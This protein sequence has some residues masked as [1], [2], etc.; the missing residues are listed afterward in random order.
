MLVQIIGGEQASYYGLVSSILPVFLLVTLYSNIA[1]A[2]KRLHDLGYAGFLALALLIPFVNL[3]FTI[4]VGILP[5]AAGPNRYGV[6][7][8]VPPS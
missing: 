3:A 8:D 6:A 5:G 4:W 2:V 1:V 7:P